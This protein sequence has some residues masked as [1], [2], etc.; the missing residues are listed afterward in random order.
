VLERE[1]MKSRVEGRVERR[2]RERSEARFGPEETVE[3]DI[4]RGA[5]SGGVFGDGQARE[6]LFVK[7]RILEAREAGGAKALDG[8]GIVAA[9]VRDDS[10]VEERSVRRALCKEPRGEQQ[11]GPRR[12]RG[13]APPSA[14]GCSTRRPLC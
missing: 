13:E 2:R 3:R 5:L 10:G 1:L 14:R 7:G 12:A 11:S 6:G 8:I 9:L 4:P